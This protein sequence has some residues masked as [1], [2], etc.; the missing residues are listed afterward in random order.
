MIFILALDLFLSVFGISSISISNYIMAKR[1]IS[2]PP[3]DSPRTNT[4]ADELVVGTYDEGV[5]WR[6]NREDIEKTIVDVQEVGNVGVRQESNNPNWDLSSSPDLTIL[7]HPESNGQDRRLIRRKSTPVITSLALSESLAKI[8]DIKE[9]K[10]ERRASKAGIEFENMT[11]EQQEVLQKLFEASRPPGPKSVKA[12]SSPRRATHV[13]STVKNASTRKGIEYARAQV[14]KTLQLQ[15]SQ[16]MINHVRRFLP[17]E[18]VQPWDTTLKR[19]GRHSPRVLVTEDDIKNR[20]YFQKMRLPNVKTNYDSEMRREMAMHDRIADPLKKVKQFIRR[21]AIGAKKKSRRQTLFVIKKSIIQGR[22]LCGKKVTNMADFCDAVDKNGDGSLDRE[23]IN[24]ALTRM[25]VGLPESA[26]KAF[27]DMIDKNGDGDIDYQEL[28]DALQ[29]PLNTKE[30]NRR[31]SVKYN[32]ANAPK[33]IQFK[34]NHWVPPP[35]GWGGI[36]I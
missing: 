20:T 4:Y 28:A 22:S 35:A 27:L 12:D 16:S 21:K 8:G 2:S 14:Q 25:G 18:Q 9:L 19:H 17:Q 11:K 30:V 36:G 34:Q 26:Q 29:L 13:G 3:A 24:S 5:S 32:S 15:T 31:N 7:P 33:H 23:E 6:D 1:K 10:M